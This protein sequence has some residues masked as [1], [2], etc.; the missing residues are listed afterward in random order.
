MKLMHK[1]LLLAVIPLVAIVVTVAYVNFHTSK[2][3]VAREIEQRAQAMLTIHIERIERFF[4]D[5]IETLRTIAATPVVRKGDLGEVLPYLAREQ[6]RLSEFIEGLYY[7]DKE[8]TVHGAAGEVFSVRDRYYFPQID[9]GETVITKV[10]E[11]RATQKPIVL[12]LVPIFDEE[13]NRLGA[14]GGTV[15]L[16]DILRMIV[17]IE[18]GESGFALMVDEDGQIVTG[19][20]IEEARESIGPYRTLASPGA[21]S[22]WGRL[23]GTLRPRGGGMTKFLYE[24]APYSVYFRSMKTMNWTLALA[25]RESEIY[26]SIDRIKRLNLLICVLVIVGI[27]FFVLGIK[28]VLIN[29]I[30]AL[31][32]VQH[33][34]QRGNLSARANSRSAD[35]IGDLARSFNEMLDRLHEQTHALTREIDE[36]KL[37][38]Q[39]LRASE[40]RY[41]FLYDDNP[42]MY[43]TIA[44]DGAVLSVNQCGCE[45]LG[46][47]SE[48]LIGQSVL[49][50]FLDEDK[51]A[52]ARSVEECVR[53]PGRVFHWELRKVH[54]SGEVIWVKETARAV[55]DPDGKTVVLIVCENITGQKQAEEE[56]EALQEQ[57][58]QAQ[59]MESVGRLAGGVAHDFNNMLGVILGHAEMALQEPGLSQTIRANIEEIEKAAQRSANLTRQLLAFARR[60]S[61]S[62]QVLELNDTVAGMLK[63]LQRLIGESIELVWKPAANLWPV[64]IDPS[65]VDQVLANLCVNARDAMGASGCLTIE[66]ENRTLDETGCSFQPDCIPGDYV[67]LSVSDTGKGMDKATLQHIFEPFFTTKEMGQGTGLGLAMVYGIVRQ[68]D[69]FINVYSEPEQ[70]TIFKIYLPRAG[71]SVVEKPAAIEPKPVRGT[72]TVLLVEDETA[73]LG[74]VRSV[75]E[76]FGYSVLATSDPTEAVALAQERPGPIHLLVTDVVMPGMSGKELREKMTVLYPNIQTLFISGYTAD[77]IADHGVIDEG[78]Y[79]LQKPFSANI[80]A[81]RVREILDR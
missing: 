65:Q 22:E 81:S 5:K 56:K 3:I 44:P 14:L 68:N 49:K 24:S 39:A 43:F 64:K 7:N 62:P 19:A 51:D 16:E 76:K 1:L 33:E 15:L 75:L 21:E 55:Q 12:I 11:S 69:G 6:K 38:E 50:V 8:G 2:S 29:P 45:Q 63:M 25:Y 23:I 80:L 61:I 53:I 47:S 52:A 77:V 70:G 35:E 46:Y 58:T 73:I 13:G 27:F 32:T 31:E 72:E 66:T 79:F 30:R 54:R 41:R 9:R 40:E 60:Q 34:L 59:K 42:S 4:D 71:A 18:V 37:A 74:L 67:V 36:R 28:R 26:A 78:V 20:K 17:N 57:L 48:E 10:I